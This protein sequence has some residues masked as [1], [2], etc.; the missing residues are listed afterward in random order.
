MRMSLRKKTTVIVILIT[1]IISVIS[2]FVSFRIYISTMD[3]YYIGNITRLA[4]TIAERVDGDLIEYYLSDEGVVDDRYYEILGELI[5]FRD[6]IGMDCIN[7]VQNNGNFSYNVMD[8]DEDGSILKTKNV[9]AEEFDA[10]MSK[11]QVSIPATISNSEYGWWCSG[12]EPIYNSKGEGVALVGVEF[13]MDGIINQRN[14]FLFGIIGA[15]IGAML[16]IIVLVVKI[17]DSTVVKPIN[18]LSQVTSKYVES[19]DGNVSLVLESLNIN[20]RDEIEELLNSFKKM[21]HEMNAYIKNLTTVTAEKERISTELEVATMIQ[22]GILPSKFPDEEEYSLY[23][24]MNPAKEVGGDFY[25]FFQIDDNRMAIVIADV[26]G[27]GIPAALFMMQ[28]MALI[29][30]YA[31]MTRDPSQALT[32]ANE[33]LCQNNKAEMF[34]TA[35]IAVIELDTGKFIYA[36]AG[37]NKP[38]ILRKNGGFNW[39]ATKPGFV[40]AGMEGIKYQAYED[41]FEEGEAIYMYTDGVTEALNK[42]AEFYGDS[43][44]KELLNKENVKDLSMNKLLKFI[45]DNLAEFAEG[46]DQADDITML[47]FQFNKKLITKSN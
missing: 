20:T 23:A 22:A 45:R 28:S 16:T 19:M 24:T 43:R 44:L 12:Y 18:L 9:N 10:Y 21:E 8:T 40:L 1:M 35:F 37:H 4:K 33:K 15:L 36:N 11:G 26:S 47:G 39:L 41:C 25:D 14:Q 38:L 30:N 27:K 13:A 42:N 5:D 7:I 3:T 29:R 31:Q 46:A 34:V 17:I 32:L 6:D 2:V